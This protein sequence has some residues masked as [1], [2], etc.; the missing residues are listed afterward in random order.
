MSIEKS[1]LTKNNIIDLLKEKYN[2]EEKVEIVKLNRGSSNLFK[3]NTY[4]E[5]YILKEFNS[6]KSVSLVEK[7]I[8]IINYLRK[9]NFSV[10]KYILLN[11]GE[12]YFVFNGKVLILQQYIEGYTIENNTGNYEKMIESAAILGKLTKELAGYDNLDEEEI[13]EIWFSKKS[14]QIGIEKLKKERDNIKNDNKYQE[15]FVT[16]LRD[17]ILIANKLL[18]KLDFSVIR[19][20]SIVNAHGDYSIQ[21]LIFND[22]NPT[23]VI[24]FEAVKKMPIVWEIMR[25]YSYVDEK[26]K[27]GKID[28]NNLVQYFK[29]FSKFFKLNEYDLK[30]APHIYL[31]QLVG[32][33]F[34]YREYNKDYTQSDL[35]KFALFRTNLCRNLDNNLD[36]ISE[37][38]LKNV[39]YEKR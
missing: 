5:T 28:I 11:N 33:T 12:Y 15:Q 7:E 31:M 16:D 24:D 23:T 8:N 37:S 9:R 2:I 1:I 18:N 21:Q 36:E 26:A 32:S 30:Y 29:E 22:D 6:T 13:I 27:E 25:S 3:I 34:G 35:L 19:K 14:V 4:N 39:P 38:L 20:L 10:P 17:K